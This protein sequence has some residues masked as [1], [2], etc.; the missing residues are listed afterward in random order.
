M[1]AAYYSR[2]RGT[3]SLRVPHSDR[4]QRRIDMAAIFKFIVVVGSM[5]SG[6]FSIGRSSLRIERKHQ[7]TKTHLLKT[8]LAGVLLL[9]TSLAVKCPDHPTY[10]TKWQSDFSG[11]MGS[12]AAK[13]IQTIGGDVGGLNQEFGVVTPSYSNH[14]GCDGAFVTDYL[15]PTSGTN[16]NP[17]WH[18]AWM[19]VASRIPNI[20]Q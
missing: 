15:M 3:S 19:H 8:L 20:N 13:T 16:V 7:V 4:Q 6:A 12:S 2:Q 11:C 10:G 5:V 18:W 14:P 1:G 17:G 9:F